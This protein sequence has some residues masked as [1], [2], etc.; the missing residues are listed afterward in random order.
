MLFKSRM[1]KATISAFAEVD[2]VLVAKTFMMY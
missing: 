2:K 1:K